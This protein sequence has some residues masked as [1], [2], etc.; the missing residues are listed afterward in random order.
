MSL[1]PN[2]ATTILVVEDDLLVGEYLKIRLGTAGYTICWATTGAMALERLGEMRPQLMLLDLGLPVVNGFDVLA[3]V[4]RRR[5]H[6][7]MPIVVLTA[8][9]GSE[10]VKRA[11]ALGAS[12]FL[13][14]PCEALKLLKR[15]EHH[16]ATKPVI[17]RDGQAKRA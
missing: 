7:D 14:K 8:R 10:D 6:D 12:D 9:H 2:W 1:H 15:V 3:E 13:V 16:L 17:R 11:M 5:I 4:R